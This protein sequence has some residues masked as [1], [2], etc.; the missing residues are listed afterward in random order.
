LH[1][2]NRSPRATLNVTF[3]GAF[4]EGIISTPIGP[5]KTTHLTPEPGWEAYLNLIAWFFAWYR[6]LPVRRINET[7]FD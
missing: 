2:A 5:G 7:I 4:I 6:G 1:P 3:P